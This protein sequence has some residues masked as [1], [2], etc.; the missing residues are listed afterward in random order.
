MMNECYQLTKKKLFIIFG[1][2]VAILLSLL[3]FAAIN[4]GYYDLLVSKSL[5]VLNPGERYSDSTFGKFYEIFGEIPI[6]L[7]IVFS[8]LMF[9]RVVRILKINKTL[10]L[11]IRII[12][13]IGSFMFGVFAFHRMIK[14]SYQV[15]FKDS[16][17]IWCKMFSLSLLV[18]IPFSIGLIVLFSYIVK[19]LDL[20]PKQVFRYIFV[21]GFSIL[22]AYL[23]VTVLK[24][25]V[26][27]NRYRALMF[28]DNGSFEMFTPWFKMGGKR[29]DVIGAISDDFK[30][31]PSGH[32][33]SACSLIAMILFPV[34][35]PKFNKKNIKELCVIIPFLHISL[36]MFGRVVMGAHY[37]SDVTMAALI[38]VIYF[39]IFILIEKLLYKK[40]V[41]SIL[42]KVI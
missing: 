15:H 8:F 9:E 13:F 38:S 27:R 36:T 28:L 21:A 6:Y 31:Y 14:Y 1:I 19:R 23:S 4:N 24:G 37:I 42:D 7:I 32:T 16:D 20:E 5:V 34:Y 40:N 30:S 17:D 11:I 18:T 22:L 26:Q 2:T 33:Q 41:Y 12:L 10:V 35:F 39:L 3:I 25:I 29:M